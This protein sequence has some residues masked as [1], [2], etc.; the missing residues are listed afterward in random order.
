MR[1]SFQVLLVLFLLLFVSMFSFFIGKDKGYKKAETEYEKIIEFYESE[2][3]FLA[4]IEEINGNHVF[5]KGLD[6]NC[7]NHR[8]EYVF[9]ITDTVDLIWHCTPITIEQLHEGD[10]ISITYSGGILETSP[11]EFENVIKVEV[12]DDE[13]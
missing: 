11:G 13:L 1:K 6:V 4:T 12:L 5:V 8:G 2:D 3:T 7:I 9:S 10:I